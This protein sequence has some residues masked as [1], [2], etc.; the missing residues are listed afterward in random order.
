MP[1]AKGALL[2]QATKDLLE[3]TADGIK[4]I[5]IPGVEAIPA[6]PLRIIAIFEVRV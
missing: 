4:G 2:L 6:V 1:L 5:G 3:T